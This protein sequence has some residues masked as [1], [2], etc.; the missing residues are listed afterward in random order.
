MK[1]L[2]VDFFIAIVSVTIIVFSL[3]YVVSKF[4]S[5]KLTTRPIFGRMAKKQES[6]AATYKLNDYKRQAMLP[7][8]IPLIVGFTDRIRWYDIL[9]LIIAWSAGVAFN[10]SLHRIGNRFYDMITRA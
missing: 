1:R 6:V 3:T 7:A 5:T 4:T 2:S 8:I 9:L 10:K